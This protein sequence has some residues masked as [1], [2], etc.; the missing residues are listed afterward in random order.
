M[1][2][3]NNVPCNKAVSI[4]EFLAEKSIPVIR[5]PHV[6][7]ISVHVNSFYSP[8]QKTLERAPFFYFGHFPEER[9]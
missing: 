8:A 6:R 3:H 7:R 5:Q 4:N 2:H 9:N 1:L